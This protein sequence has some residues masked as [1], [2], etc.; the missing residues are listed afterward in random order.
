MTRLTYLIIGKWERLRATLVDTEHEVQNNIYLRKFI[1][2]NNICE[3]GVE[4]PVRWCAAAGI[5]QC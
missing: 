2:F 4:C 1:H 5:F 3:S